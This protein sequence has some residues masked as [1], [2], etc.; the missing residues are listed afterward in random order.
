MTRLHHTYPTSNC[1]GVQRAWEAGAGHVQRCA[2]CGAEAEPPYE[3]HDD[4]AL[5]SD[6]CA[7][8]YRDR[9]GIGVCDDH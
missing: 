9:Y 2:V 3:T 8:L 5:C 1:S 6:E 7:R 4:D